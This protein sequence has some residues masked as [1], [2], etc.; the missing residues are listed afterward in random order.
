MRREELDAMEMIRVSDKREIEGI[1]SRE[2]DEDGRTEASKRRI[3][4]AENR[5]KTEQTKKKL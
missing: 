1:G 5:N 2:R 3:L 4:T